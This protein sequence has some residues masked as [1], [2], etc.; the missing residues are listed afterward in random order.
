MVN[1]SKWKKLNELVVTSNKLINNLVVSDRTDVA[2]DRQLDKAGHIQKSWRRIKKKH[3]FVAWRNETLFT[4]LQVSLF[5]KADAH[6]I[7]IYIFKVWRETGRQRDKEI[8][9]YQ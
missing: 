2:A 7:I 4:V 6:D 5:L 3:Y 9:I 8:K 1:G